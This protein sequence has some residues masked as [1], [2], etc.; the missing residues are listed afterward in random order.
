MELTNL[1][2]EPKERMKPLYAKILLSL[3]CV[4]NSFWIWKTIEEQKKQLG[5]EPLK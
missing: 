3:V 1:F 4:S 2:I 5:F